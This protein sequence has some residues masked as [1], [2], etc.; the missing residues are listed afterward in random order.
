MQ[1]QPVTLLTRTHFK[2]SRTQFSFQWMLLCY[3]KVLATAHPQPAAPWHLAAVQLFRNT[4]YGWCVGPASK[5]ERRFGSCEDWLLHFS[6]ATLHFPA[7]QSII[8][9]N[10]QR[11]PEKKTGGK[12]RSPILQLVVNI[13]LS[14]ASAWNSQTV[15][16]VRISR[17]QVEKS[18]K[19]SH[20]QDGTVRAHTSANT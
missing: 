18:R 14:V 20:F 6:H 12:K 9:L 15:L 16:I 19:K 5:A 17:K 7:F 13:V 10:V 3:C 2:C 8:H 4:N 11:L 1:V